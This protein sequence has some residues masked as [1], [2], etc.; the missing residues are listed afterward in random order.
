L[1]LVYRRVKSRPDNK[2]TPEQ[3]TAKEN[4]VSKAFMQYL[5]GTGDFSDFDPVDW[6]ESKNNEDPLAVWDAFENSRHLTELCHFASMNLHIVAN[7]AGCERTFSRTKIEQA[8]RRNRL[9]L[10]KTDKRTKVKA[11]IRAEHQ[12]QGLYKP[13]EGRKS[14]ETLLSVPRYRDLLEDQDDEDP[15]ERGRALVSSP[16]TWQT[17]VAKWIGDARA[18][19]RADNLAD[20]S[21]TDNE[22]SGNDEIISRIPNWLPVWKLTTLQVLQDMPALRSGDG[23]PIRLI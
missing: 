8:D 2:D 22:V 15:S 14:I 6:K 12:M 18:A 13:R 5:S 17:Q 23:P 19:E 10:E 21:S 9:G 16:D 11:Q 3:R 20:A 1:I 7:Q 4:E